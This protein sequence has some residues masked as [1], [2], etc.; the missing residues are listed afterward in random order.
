MSDIV[1]TGISWTEERIAELKQLWHAGYSCSQIAS[2]L[3]G[4]LSRNAV[5][6]KIT[7]LG[8]ARSG[9]RVRQPASAPT[10]PR[11]A[12]QPS[13]FRSAPVKA[14][15]PQTPKPAPVAAPIIK[16][17]SSSGCKFPIGDPQIAGFHFCNAP[18]LIA[19]PYCCKHREIAFVPQAPRKS[20]TELARSL[21]RYI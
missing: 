1:F 9:D 11:P 16:F 14:K 20:G 5:I 10:K 7:R 18:R 21:R 17:A 4:G 3:G 13:S 12:K 6:G 19:G 8:L 2:K 15:T